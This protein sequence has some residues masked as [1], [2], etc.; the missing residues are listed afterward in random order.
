MSLNYTKEELNLLLEESKLPVDAQ[1]LRRKTDSIL[2]TIESLSA[3]KI[4]IELEIKQQK[5]VL[6]RKRLELKRRSKSNQVRLK[7]ALESAGITEMPKENSE[8]LKLDQNLLRESSK[9]LEE[10]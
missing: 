8:I 10:D 2:R 4:S 9:I 3:K 6:A 1:N 5:R 7:A